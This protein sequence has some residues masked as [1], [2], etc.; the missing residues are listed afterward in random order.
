[1]HGVNYIFEEDMKKA[2]GDDVSYEYRKRRY[3]ERSRAIEKRF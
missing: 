3:D 2:I 1:M